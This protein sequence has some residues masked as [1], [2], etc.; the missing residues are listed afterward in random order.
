MVSNAT[1]TM[2][3]VVHALRTTGRRPSVRH[4]RPY[5]ARTPSASCAMAP[6]RMG[7]RACSKNGSAL[8]NSLYGV[9]IPSS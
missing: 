6:K 7:I 4:A 2:A 9:G 3:A 1:H 5:A 8:A